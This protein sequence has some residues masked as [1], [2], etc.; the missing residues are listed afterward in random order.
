M[1]GS[2]KGHHEALTLSVCSKQGWKYADIGSGGVRGELNAG[3]YLDWKVNDHKN[4]TLSYYNVKPFMLYHPIKCTADKS[5]GHKALMW[6]RQGM[7][8]KEKIHSSKLDDLPAGAHTGHRIENSST[9]CM[10]TCA[11]R[12]DS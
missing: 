10:D 12:C 6:T 11:R 9:T 5:L 8:I 2:G 1:T 3:G 4:M 7:T